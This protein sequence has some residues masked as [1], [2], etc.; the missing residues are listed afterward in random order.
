MSQRGYWMD[1]GT[2]ERYLQATWDILES[3]VRTGVG[4][5]IAAT[6]NGVLCAE[7]HP[8]GAVHGPAIIGDGCSIA[9]DATVTGRSVLGTGVTIGPGATVDS[10]VLL[11]GVS[12]GERTRINR[13]IVG[14]GAQIAD[15]CRLAETAMVGRRAPA[16]APT[17]RSPRGVRIFPD[18]ELPDRGDQLLRKSRGPR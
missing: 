4:D 10:S 6:G 17:T 1:I 16:W 7:V 13:C 2:P 11:D 14:P 18:V 15:H 8:D 3:E 5:A 12:V 9:A